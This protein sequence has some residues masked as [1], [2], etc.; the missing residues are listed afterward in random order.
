MRK[1]KL[2]YAPCFFTRFCQ[3]NT[4]TP[5]TWAQPSTLVC[6]GCCDGK[7]RTGDFSTTEIDFSQ[8]ERRKVQDQTVPGAGEDLLTGSRRVGLSLWAPRVGGAGALRGL[9]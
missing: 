4:S 9:P 7:P 3:N 5:L 2:R 8:F 1:W 6:L